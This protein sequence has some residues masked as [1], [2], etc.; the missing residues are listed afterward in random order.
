MGKLSISETEIYAHRLNV[1]EM[2]TAERDMLVMATIE[3]VRQ[4][5]I[6]RK[7]KP[8]ESTIQVPQH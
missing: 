8:K 6:K 3:A 1:A 5:C 4:G 2:S 7:L